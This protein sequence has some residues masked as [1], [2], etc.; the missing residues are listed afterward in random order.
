[1]MQSPPAGVSPSARQEAGKVGEE[2]LAA[3]QIGPAITKVNLKLIQAF[4]LVAESG[5]FREAAEATG[6]SQ[7]A[8][9]AQIRQLEGQIGVQLLRRT[10]R[11]VSLTAEGEKL[12]GHARKAMA[13]LQSGFEAIRAAAEAEKRRVHFSCTPLIAANY[14]PEMLSLFARRYP[15]VEVRCVEAGSDRLLDGVRNGTSA[16]AVGGVAPEPGLDLD[17][18]LED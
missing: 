7:S 5:S 2:E 13:E 1:M 3:R 9:S 8:V 16:F 14:V 11:R 12:I 10:T 15:A 6:R 4:L 18:F 17:V